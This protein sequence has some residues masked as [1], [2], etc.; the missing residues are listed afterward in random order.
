MKQYKW[1]KG[2]KRAN[3][4]IHYYV[5]PPGGSRQRLPDQYDSHEFAK[6]YTAALGNYHNREQVKPAVAQPSA[7][8]VTFLPGS[9]GAFILEFCASKQ[10]K[11]YAKGTRY[12]YNKALDYLRDNLGAGRLDDINVDLIDQYTRTIESDSMADLQVNMLSLLWDFA[13]GSPNFKRAG[14]TSPAIDA[15]TR[16]SVKQPHREW[17]EKVQREFLAAANPSMQMF[18]HLARETGQRLGDIVKMRWQDFDGTTILIARTEKT[19][20]PVYVKVSAR[21]R[22]ILDKAPRI[23]ETI[24]TSTWKRPYN[25]SSISHRVGDVLDEIGYGR[26]TFSAHGLRKTFASE[27]ALAGGSASE[28]KAALGHKSD[29]MALYYASQANSRDLS[30]NAVDKIDAARREVVPIRRR[31]AG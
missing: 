12:N 16:Y 29:K 18:F 24:L 17:P 28:L 1:V 6:A 7:E 25:K 26:R 20:T 11:G 23:A 5:Q 10:F 15:R 30:A 13:V 8:R 3:G 19:G 14:R 4:A 2:I 31:K 21:L 22:A 9:V 27:I